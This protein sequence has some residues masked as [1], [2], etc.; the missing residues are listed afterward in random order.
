MYLA[1]TPALIKPLFKGRMWNVPGPGK[2]LYLTFD[3]GPIPEVTPWVLDILASRGA[4]ATFFVIGRNA[5][6]HPSLL[7]RI[8]KEGHGLGNHTWDHRNGWK[9]PAF[10]YLRSVMRCQAITGTPLF[11]PP[12]GRLTRRQA[13]AL[14]ARFDLVMWEVLSA[15][16]DRNITGERCLQNVVSNTRA[17]SII[18]FHDSLKAEPRLRFALPKVLEHFSAQGYEFKVLALSAERSLH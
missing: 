6:D 7:D 18:V 15:D 5:T 17:G 4:K 13:R 2:D 9:T 12:Y 3:D 1:R 8:R 14:R 16:F 10:A 11:R